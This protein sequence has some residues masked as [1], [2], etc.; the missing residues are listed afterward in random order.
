MF[1]SLLTIFV[2][3]TVHGLDPSLL[4]LTTERRRGTGGI[5]FPTPAGVACE[6]VCVGACTGSTACFDESAEIRTFDEHTGKQVTVKISDLAHDKSDPEVQTADFLGDGTHLKAATETLQ[7][8]VPVEGDWTFYEI[9]AVTDSTLIPETMQKVSLNTTDDH[10]W[11]V[12]DS[13]GSDG[14]VVHAAE[15][16]VGDHVLVFLEDRMTPTVAKVIFTRSFQLPVKYAAYTESGLIV[17]NGVLTTVFCDHDSDDCAA[18]L[19]LRDRLAVW[20]RRHMERIRD[21]NKKFTGL[22]LTRYDST[23]RSKREDAG[24]RDDIAKLTDK[25]E[26]MG[27]TLKRVKKMVAKKSN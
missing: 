27:K 18:N 9:T 8:V 19:A 20:K 14:C 22:D 26:K 4:P 1:L 5:G 11:V 2:T 17:A 6:F 12:V 25:M 7:A 3:S 10:G 21:A 13:D 24:L 23:L 15:V 16:R